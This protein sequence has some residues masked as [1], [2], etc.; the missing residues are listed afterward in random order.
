MENK[1]NNSEMISKKGEEDQEQLT[2]INN[3]E[4]SIKD[5]HDNLAL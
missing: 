1:S 4:E 2:I 3:T 5:Q